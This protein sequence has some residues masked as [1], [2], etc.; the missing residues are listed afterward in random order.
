MSRIVDVVVIGHWASYQNDLGYV[1]C[2]V[3]AAYAVYRVGIGVG[4]FD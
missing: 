4:T 3:V 2:G 1:S